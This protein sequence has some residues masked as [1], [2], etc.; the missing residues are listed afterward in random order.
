MDIQFDMEQYHQD[1]KRYQRILNA[2]DYDISIECRR[3]WQAVDRIIYNWERVARKIP[4]EMVQC[5]RK[6]K[7][8]DQ[9]KKLVRD[10][11][12]Y[13]DEIEQALTMFQLLYK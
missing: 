5:R 2:A 8:T 1:K 10:Y 7:F 9:Y 12:S 11:Y 4:V 13:R 6:R 3:D